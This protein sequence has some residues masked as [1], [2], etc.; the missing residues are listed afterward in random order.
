MGAWSGQ[1]MVLA[2]TPPNPAEV[3]AQAGPAPGS[4]QATRHSSGTAPHSRI[5]SC[6][7]TPPTWALYFRRVRDRTRKGLVVGGAIAGAVS[8][9]F[10]LLF[11]TIGRWVIRTRVL[12]KVAAK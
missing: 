9:L 11:P 2:Q 7:P 3:G 6:Y 10:F 12:P 5:P 4:P 1:R 8:I